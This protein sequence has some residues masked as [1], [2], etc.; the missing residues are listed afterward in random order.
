MVMIIE[1]IDIH[2]SYIRD[3]FDFVQNTGVILYNNFVYEMV[4]ESLHIQTEFVQRHLG[5]WGMGE[6]FN[7]YLN[8]VIK[9]TNGLCMGSPSSDGDGFF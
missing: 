2:F 6:G 4:P 7:F 8:C 9:F 1:K 5:Y 3:N